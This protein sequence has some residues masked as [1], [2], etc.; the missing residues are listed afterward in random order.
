MAGTLG[1]DEGEIGIEEVIVD[2]SFL[3]HL[4]LWKMMYVYVVYVCMYVF[5]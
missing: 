1:E 3:L 2:N 5:M 4:L